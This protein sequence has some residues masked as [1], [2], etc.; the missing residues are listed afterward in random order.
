MDIR[1]EF[2]EH[3]I[4]DEG[5]ETLDKLGRAFTD[6]LTN[7]EAFCPPGREAALVKTHI[8]TAYHWAVQSIASSPKYQRLPD[9]HVPIGDG[10]NG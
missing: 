9:D 7:T 4:T 1:K 8:E 5:R 3:K 2:A 10:R 6:V